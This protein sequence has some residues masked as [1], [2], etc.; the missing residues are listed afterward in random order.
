[1]SEAMSEWTPERILAILGAIGTAFGALAAVI[2]ALGRR[3]EARAL[4]AVVRGVERGAKRLTTREEIETKKTIR[5]EATRAG[6]EGVLSRIV[7]A[8]T[9]SA[10]AASEP[11]PRPEGDR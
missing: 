2:Q 7:R 4:R 3:G 5:E 9:T 6:A 1:M 10:L 11:L 8:E